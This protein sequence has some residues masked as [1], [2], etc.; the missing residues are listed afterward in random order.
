MLKHIQFID[1]GQH[2]LTLPGCL[3]FDP[4]SGRPQPIEAE[5]R[6]NTKVNLGHG[7]NGAGIGP[8]NTH[9][10]ER[11]VHLCQTSNRMSKP[12]GHTRSLVG[13]HARLQSHE[14]II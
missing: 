5:T 8:G 12:F 3:G 6:T 1:H 13:I 10:I 4:P 9:N 11:R 14:G 7:G 2:G